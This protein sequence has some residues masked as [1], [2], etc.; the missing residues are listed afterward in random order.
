MFSK[1]K[2]L[3]LNRKSLWVYLTQVQ[4]TG[5]VFLLFF[6]LLEFPI[7]DTSFSHDFSSFGVHHNQRFILFFFFNTRE[8]LANGYNTVSGPGHIS[9]QPA[10]PS[11]SHT[12]VCPRGSIRRRSIQ[13]HL[14]ACCS[15]PPAPSWTHAPGSSPAHW[16]APL[17]R[18]SSG[19][20]LGSGSDLKTEAEWSFMGPFPQKPVGRMC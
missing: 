15:P 7:S 14:P 17:P 20:S 5:N 16:R 2:Q 12:E 9:N 4:E 8:I 19:I 11:I 1:V 13:A 18:S 3:V 6:F 10:V